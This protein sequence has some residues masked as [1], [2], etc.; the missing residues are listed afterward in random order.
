MTFLGSI[1]EHWT[2]LPRGPLLFSVLGIAL[3]VSGPAWARENVDDRDQA[4]ATLA[5]DDVPECASRADIKAH[6]EASLEIFGVLD[7]DV[8]VV[9][10]IEKQK[11]NRFHV[12]LTV[13]RENQLG[14]EREYRL[15]RTDCASLGQLLHMTLDRFFTSFPAWRSPPPVVEEEMAPPAP[16]P[17]EEETQA[18]RRVEIGVFLT[19]A[20][21]VAPVGGSLDLGARADLGDIHRFGASLLVRESLPAQLAG[22]RFLQTYGLLGISWQYAAYSIRPR[23]ELLG[24]F[25]NTLGVH[26]ENNESTWLFWMEARAILEKRWRK[27]A[28]GL[29]IAASPMRHQAKSIL[30]NESTGTMVTDTREISWL[31]LGLTLTIFVWANRDER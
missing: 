16:A 6:L 2:Q 26:F 3:I 10:T 7:S 31:R 23:L 21:E 14:L 24:G 1:S 18:Q 9:V 22:N 19:P 28:L 20:L 17:V 11:E 25:L 5:I 29:D 4:G 8:S 13:S 27:V 30:R 12:K 15:S